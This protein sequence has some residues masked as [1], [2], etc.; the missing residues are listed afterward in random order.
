MV[1]GLSR[2]VYTAHSTQHTQ[3]DNGYSTLVYCV[4]LPYISYFNFNFISSL[5]LPSSPFP[6]S[7]S[8]RTVCRLQY[9]E[10]SRGYNCR[11]HWLTPF[12]FFIYFYFIYFKSDIEMQVFT[13]V[14]NETRLIL[15]TRKLR[16]GTLT[17]FQNI[18]TR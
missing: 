2:T 10:D 15:D 11:A 7:L 18:V 4:M 5:P 12:L 13:V 1:S 9:S 3:P 8:S 17:V 6:L 16:V 14:I